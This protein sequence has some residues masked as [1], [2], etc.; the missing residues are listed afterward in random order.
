MLF[1]QR[2][3]SDMMPEL[4]LALHTTAKAIFFSNVSS[5]ASCSAA[6][7]YARARQK[8]KFAVIAFRCTGNRIGQRDVTVDCAE[9][10][11]EQDASRADQDN[12]QAMRCQS[13][14]KLWK[15]LF[16]KKRKKHSPQ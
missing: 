3:A 11:Q 16:E 6:N 2:I 5:P 14:S 15:L 8:A 1:V 10:A 4:G 12:K 7:L 9:L 13:H